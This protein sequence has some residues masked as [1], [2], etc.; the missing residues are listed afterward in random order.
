MSGC[1]SKLNLKVV[2]HRKGEAADDKATIM[3]GPILMFLAIYNN[4]INLSSYA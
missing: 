1:T 2:I 3:E 4:S